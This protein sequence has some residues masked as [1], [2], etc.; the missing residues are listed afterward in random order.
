MDL[1]MVDKLSSAFDSKPRVRVY[2]VNRDAAGQ[3]S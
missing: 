3:R 2:Q 1:K